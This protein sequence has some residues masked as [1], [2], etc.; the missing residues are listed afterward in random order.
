MA[1][2]SESI[3]KEICDALGLKEVI[4]IDI[5]LH[6]NNAATITVKS[7]LNKYDAEK[8]KTVLIKYR[9]FPIEESGVKDVTTMGDEYRNYILTKPIDCKNI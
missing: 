1:I 9:L 8:I 6:L 3:G 5:S 4:D 2:S 7:Y